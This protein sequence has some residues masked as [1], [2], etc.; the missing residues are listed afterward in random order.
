MEYLQKKIRRILEIYGLHSIARRYF[1]IN[2]FDGIIL[3]LSIFLIFFISGYFSRILIIKTVLAA[4]FGASLSGFIGAYFSEISERKHYRKKYEKLLLRS[5]KGSIIQK[6]EKYA[7]ILMGLIEGLSPMI[8]AI[9][10]LLPIFLIPD[11]ILSILF[12]MLI[13]IFE[14]IFIGYFLSNIAGERKI[15]TILKLLFISIVLTFV[16]V[17]LDIFIK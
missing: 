10:A 9:F 4:S 3:V 14:I 12:G 11:I 17:F 15:E 5:L 16:I 13:C 8:F 6:Y 7:A 1:I 2:S